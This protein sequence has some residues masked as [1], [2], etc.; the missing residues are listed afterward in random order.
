M[1]RQFYLLLLA[2]LAASICG[3]GKSAPAATQK[4]PPAKVATIAKEAE[5]ATI[6][7]TPEAE[8]R[9]GIQLAE[10]E[11][12]RVTRM[13]TLGGEV[14]IPPGRAVVV[15]APLA[16][17]LVA[18]KDGGPPRPGQV[19]TKG[20]IVFA[21]EPLLSPPERLRL[22]EVL[23]S[24][25]SSRA[26]AEAQVD[27][28]EVQ[29][30]A[31][32]VMLARAE[33]LVRDKAGSM[34]SRDDAKAQLDVAAATLRGAE[35]RR[36][37]LAKV[38][39]DTD[40]SLAALPIASPEGGLLQNLHATIG[41]TVTAGAPLFEVSRQDTV[42]I[43]VPIYAGDLSKIDT[44]AAASIA[45]LGS[46]AIAL[47]PRLAKPVAAPPAA[48]A[49]TATVDAT[50]ELNNSDAALRPGQRVAVTVPLHGDDESLVVPW[51]AVLHDI[52]G[53]TWVYEATGPQTFIRR[54]VHVRH[55]LDSLA[56]LAAGP[57]PGSKIVVSGAAELF[58]A[59]FGFG[60][61]EAAH[62]AEK[63]E[64]DD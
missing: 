40:A 43:R 39:L 28:A 37:I 48:N 44:S 22:A 5:L 42:W 25:A 4:T 54:R 41:Q 15:T 9:L 61:Q 63:E 50:Y 59:E 7:L 58:G 19:L 2:S 10:V 47:E 57:K 20:R 8:K 21:L 24:L 23:V 38:S 36:E 13:R 56:V 64:D 12:K 32:K 34:K 3:C 60:M 45:S 49:I 55:V 30:G 35:A 27:K 53:G 31:A 11:R 16:G 17:T 6:V 1:N 26:D 62:G 51:S 29:L 33:Q 14:T 52:H 18:S 46:V